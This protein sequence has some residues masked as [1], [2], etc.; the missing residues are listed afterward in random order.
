MKQHNRFGQYF[1]N[2]M[3]YIKLV[4]DG[5]LDESHKP[6]KGQK[7]SHFPPHLHLFSGK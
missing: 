2:C 5:I 7:Y 1:S 4:V 6:L 3:S